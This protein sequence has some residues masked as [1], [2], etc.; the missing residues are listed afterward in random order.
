MLYCSTS[1]PLHAPYAYQL[2]GACALLPTLHMQ[3]VPH[4]Q[5]AS[6][7]QLCFMHC[8]TGLREGM[9]VLAKMDGQFN[10]FVHRRGCFMLL[11]GSGRRNVAQHQCVGC[12]HNLHSTRRLAMR[13]NRSTPALMNNWPRPAVSLFVWLPVSMSIKAHHQASAEI[14]PNGR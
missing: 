10:V 9:W 8:N 6:T 12:H 5:N 3:A 7:S 13:V 11:W 2:L 14:R 4:I 1:H